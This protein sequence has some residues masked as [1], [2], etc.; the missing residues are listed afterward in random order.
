MA[1]GFGGLRDQQ[2]SPRAMT[3]CSPQV[4]LDCHPLLPIV[5][6]CDAPESSSD[7]GVLLLRAVD[8]RLGLTAGF[9]ERMPDLR[10]PRF[11]QHPRLEQLR[12]RVYQ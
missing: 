10:D 6:T 2:P 7:G 9:A 11:V 12:Q 5:A 4:V 3:D 8:E 1:R